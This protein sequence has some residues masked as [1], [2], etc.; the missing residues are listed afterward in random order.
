[1]T[2]TCLAVLAVWRQGLRCR[3]EKSRK[4]KSSDPDSV[5]LGG[6][7]KEPGEETE[8]GEASHTEC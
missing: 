1:M 6:E 5:T 3:V 2:Y 4:F 7:S 8:I